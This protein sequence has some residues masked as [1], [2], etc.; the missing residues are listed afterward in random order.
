MQESVDAV[1][2]TTGRLRVQVARIDGA[3]VFRDPQGKQLFHDANRWLTPV[4]VN[5]E[6]TYHSE[7]VVNMYGSH[8]G[9][10]GLGQHQAG[11]W[12][13]RGES[14]DTLQENSNVSVPLLVSSNG[15][16]IFW[17]NESRSRFNNRFGCHQLFVRRRLSD[18]R[19]LH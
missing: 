16:G 18:F 10:Y 8:E 12:N 15:Y 7:V 11:V 4:T 9:L 6:E 17:N 19:G 1:T 5:G 13:Y 2:I 3:I 14:I